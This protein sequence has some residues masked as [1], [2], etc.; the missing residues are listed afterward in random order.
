MRYTH[1]ASYVGVDATVNYIPSS[2]QT[3]HGVESSVTVNASDPDI[4]M[5]LDKGTHFGSMCAWR[6]PSH[7]SN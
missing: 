2:Q 4:T 3:A 1:V 7:S 5:K 6:I